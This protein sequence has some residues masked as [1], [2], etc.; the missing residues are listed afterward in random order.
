MHTSRTLLVPN[1]AVL[2][3]L[4][5]SL[6][7]GAT[8]AG[9]A[10][11][12]E[13]APPPPRCLPP[14][15]A[16]RSPASIAEAIDLANALPKPL[17]LPCFLESLARPLRVSATSAVISLQPA[18][19]RRSPRLFLF[20]GRL[21]SSI[22]PEGSGSALM[23]FGEF[24][25]DTRTVKG[26]IAFPIEGPLDAGAPFRRIVKDGRTSC[27]GC[28]RAE[29]SAEDLGYPGGFLS[30]ALQPQASTKVELGRVREE[31]RACNPALEP[32]RCAFFQALFGHGE[33]LPGDFAASVP[34]IFD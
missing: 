10:P 9:C 18:R 22:V 27:S 34:T 21:V 24:I 13:G 12:D 7:F 11:A 16:P 1:T 28:H 14:D 8:L 25:D 2:L 26:E 32:D 6:L 4:L 19:G 23:E 30:G 17:S 31:H 29:T 3:A 5:V 20:S 33:V 15:G